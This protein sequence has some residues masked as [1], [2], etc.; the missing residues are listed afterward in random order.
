MVVTSV[1]VPVSYSGSGF[2]GVNVIRD[3]SERFTSVGDWE[4]GS[5]VSLLSVVVSCFVY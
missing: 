2:C 4:C 5:F 3:S 1:S